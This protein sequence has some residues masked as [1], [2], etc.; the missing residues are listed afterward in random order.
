MS[1][2]E[3]AMVTEREEMLNT[4]ITKYGHESEPVLFFAEH[5]W[6]SISNREVYFKIAMNWVFVER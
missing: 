6:K 3:L 1:R 2:R 4:L 5:A